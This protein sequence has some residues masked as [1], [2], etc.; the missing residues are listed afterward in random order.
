MAQKTTKTRSDGKR[1]S[2][3]RT[4]QKRRAEQ[5]VVQFYMSKRMAARLDAAAK[6]GELS[7]DGKPV[8]NRSDVIRAILDQYL[9]RGRGRP[10]K[11]VEPE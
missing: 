5:V 7:N 1:A 3:K 11:T 2:D 9:P 10:R 8:T 4:N 6:R